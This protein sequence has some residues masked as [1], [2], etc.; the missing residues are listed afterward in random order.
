MAVSIDA[1]KV[2]E[3]LGE[4]IDKKGRKTI[5]IGF[6]DAKIAAISSIGWDKVKKEP[7]CTNTSYVTGIEHADDFFKRIWVEMNRRSSSIKQ[8]SFVFLGDG[9]EWI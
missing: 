6:R 8:S 1:A 7:F 3:K 9:A 4:E 5:E 2:R